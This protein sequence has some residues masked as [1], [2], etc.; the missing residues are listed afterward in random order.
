MLSQTKLVCVTL[1]LAT[2]QRL[3]IWFQVRSRV[4][5]MGC[6]SLL[7]YGT[8]LMPCV[9]P[10]LPQPHGHLTLLPTHRNKHLLRGFALTVLLP[11]VLFLWVS[12]YLLFTSFSKVIILVVRFSSHFYLKYCNKRSHMPFTFFSLTYRKQPGS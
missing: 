4:P 12:E 8:T 7:V 2:I 5:A 11:G 3:T 1:S 9:L 10:I 6:I